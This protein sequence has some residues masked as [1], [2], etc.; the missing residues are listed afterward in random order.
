M[1]YVSSCVVLLLFVLPSLQAEDTIR[2]SVAVGSD[3]RTS[4][5]FRGVVYNDGPVLQPW[6]ESSVGP[7]TFGMWANMDLDDF[8]G[9]LKKNRFSEV[10]LTV[11]YALPSYAGW[12]VSLGFA[13]YLF[14]NV[15]DGEGGALPGTREVIVSVGRVIT[16]G[17]S[18]KTVL[19]YDVDQVDEYHAALR[20]TYDYALTSKVAFSIYGQ[21]G[22]VGHK[23]SANGDAG[24]YDYDVRA[25]LAY[26]GT[27][28]L[29]IGVLGGYTGSL[30]TDV[31]VDPSENAYGG[32]AVTAFF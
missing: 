3:L 9:T 32:L 6:F 28:Y 15:A 22:Y 24:L 17:L 18:A 31:L 4:Y 13:E 14:P 21:G 30:D 26:G 29:E 11:N 2:P 25:S 19:S 23:L 7:V 20:L 8:G 16:G 27:D 10:D 5:I 12:D 1:K